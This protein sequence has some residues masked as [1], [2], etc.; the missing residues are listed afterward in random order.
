MDRDIHSVLAL[1]DVAF[2]GLQR[3]EHCTLHQ[4]QLLDQSMSREIS[5]QEWEA[6][7]LLDPETDWRHVPALSLDECDAAL[8]HAT[9]LSWLFYIPAYMKRALELLDDDSPDSNLPG[10]VIFHL[11]FQR[12]QQGLSWYALERFKQLTSQ[13]VEAV[14]AFLNYIVAH[15][16]EST[17]NA[18]RATEALNSY[19]GLPASK[20]PRGIEIAH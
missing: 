17:W 10:S 18:D 8:S 14:V 12:S 9:P 3:D 1:L 4:A 11:S 15:P 5:E 16:S 13:Q 2:T 7:K 20:R 19:W 6:A